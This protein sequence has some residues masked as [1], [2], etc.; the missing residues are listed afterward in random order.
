MADDK[1]PDW[2]RMP[3]NWDELVNMEGLS[4]ANKLQLRMLGKLPMGRM[5]IDSI[6]TSFK[7]E[8]S[9]FQLKH[10]RDPTEKELG[11]LLE[12]AMKGIT[13]GLTK[14]NKPQRS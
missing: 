13:A 12:T 11:P 8:L 14:G 10:G 4:R 1:K 9:S 3:S 7:T 6:F 5:L 2:S